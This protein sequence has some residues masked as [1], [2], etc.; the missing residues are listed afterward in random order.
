MNRFKPMRPMLAL[1]L[2]AGVVLPAAVP[3]TARADVSLRISPAV[4]E[5]SA[6]PGGEGVQKLKIGNGGSDPVDVGAAVELYKGADGDRSAVEWLS[7]EPGPFHLEPGEEREIEVNIDVPKG[8]ESGGRY[9]LVTFTTGAG[10]AEGN[11]AAIAGKLG[12]AFLV[13]VEG[14]GKLDRKVE[15]EHFA[16][17]LEPD[18]RVGFR[19]QL[20][21]D[22]NV[23]VLPKGAVGVADM[24][25]KPLA[26]VDLE[27]PSNLL[28]GEEALL[29]GHGSLPLSTAK[30]QAETFIDYGEEKPL[31]AKIEFEPKAAFSVSEVT[32]CENLDRGPT[33]NIALRNDGDLGLLPPVRLDLS[34][35][36]GQAAPQPA[37]ATPLV[38]WPHETATVTAD[39]TDRLVSGE[40]VLKI[41]IDYAS[42]TEDGKTVLPPFE[43][44][45]AFRIG[46]LGEGAAALCA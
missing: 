4:I 16:P 33:V 29:T 26:A 35:K 12:A 21:N 1:V 3:R 27:G 31:S 14:K 20:R 42:P 45:L 17:F 24:D 5:L 32:V 41:H 23:H 30:H 39:I 36:D 11:G 43:Q 28:P 7:V 34:A 25:G 19:A 40:Y 6:T 8:L 37:P 13:I 2:F 10:A 46:G 9:A 38:L 15:L 44:E 18:G 22:G